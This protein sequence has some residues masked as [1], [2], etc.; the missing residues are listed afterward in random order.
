M[1]RVFSIFAGMQYFLIIALQ[2]F[3]IYHAVKNRNNYYWFFVILFLPVIGSVIYLF[4]QVFNKKDLDVVQH[5]IVNAIN[6]TKKVKDLQKQLDF[7]DTFQN[8]VNLA[9]ALFENGDFTNAIQEYEKS[10]ESNHNQDVGVLKKLIESYAKVQNHEKVIFYAEKIENLTEFKGSR[11][12][13]L[14]GLALEEQGDSEKGEE[15]LK[16]IDQRY[17]NYHER[18]ILAQFLVK[19]GKTDEAKEIL[20]EIIVESQHMTKPN[21]NKYRTVVNDVKK[22]SSSL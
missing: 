18:Y 6:P 19:K 14:F 13:F 3:C 8:R 5:E 9:D 4:T 11:S 12:Q 16:Q 15:H 20:S 22:L 21:R 17:S 2:A 7:A 10:L 1:Y